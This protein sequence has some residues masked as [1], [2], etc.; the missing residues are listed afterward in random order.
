MHPLLASGAIVA[1]LVLL[2]L[3]SDWLVRGAV[4]LARRFGLSPFAIGVTVVA[5]GTSAPELF[6]SARAAMT[7]VGDLAVGNVVGSNIANVLLILGLTAVVRPVLVDRPVRRIELPVMLL[8][9]VLASMPLLD[10]MLTRLDGALLFAGVIIYVLFS[11][12]TGQQDPELRAEYEAEAAAE[13]G[14]PTSLARD[15]LFIGLGL[16]ALA[17]GAELLVRGATVI[18]IDVLG[19]PAGVVGLTVVAF[20]TSLPELAASL[21]AAIKG[22]S[23]IAVGNIVGSNIFNLLC[24]MGVAGMVAPLPAP[25]GV[26]VS[27]AVMLGAAVVCYPV[28]RR[29]HRI[30]RVQGGIMAAVYLG[31]TVALYLQTRGLPETGG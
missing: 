28:L 20:G 6:A 10:G 27:V 21:R 5:F 8:I 29:D 12:G 7:G 18:A 30:G 16:V 22:E 13:G 26:G 1:G 25:A 2:V 31:Y 14:G 24:V 19:V 11:F 17:G 4:G 3:G 15:L 9:S 23:D